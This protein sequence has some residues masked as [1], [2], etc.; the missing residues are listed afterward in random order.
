MKTRVVKSLF[1]V[2]LIGTII[3]AI[4]CGMWLSDNSGAIADAAS[5]KV[6]SSGSDVKAIQNKLIS[7]GYLPSGEADGIFGSKTKNAV[8]KFQKDKGLTAD[9]I[10]GTN[11]AKALGISVSGG[12]NGNSGY[13]GSDVYLLAKCIYSEARGEPYIGQVAVGA[14]VLNRVRDPEFPNTI[15][16]VIYQPWAFTAV[17]DGQIN[18]EPN[19]SAKR[20]AKDAMSGWDPTNGCVYYFNPDKATNKWIW[21]RPVQLVIGKHRFAT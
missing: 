3:T 8:I 17:H 5:V 1:A 7:L 14:V 13:S 2:M 19:E 6:G 12:S 18:L 15:A 21:S 10:V 9:G 20:A 11:T 16:G 4:A